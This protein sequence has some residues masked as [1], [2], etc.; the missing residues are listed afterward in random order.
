MTGALTRY[1]A[2]RAALAEVKNVDEVLEVRDEAERMRLYARQAKDRDLMANAM[3]IQLRAERRLGQMLKSAKDAGQIDRGGR[4]PEKT[5]TSAEPVSTFRLS[6]VGVD[7]KLSAK[8]QHIAQLDAA[9]F[10]LLVERSRAKIL[11]G[12]AV[13]VNPMRDLTQEEKKAKRETRERELG[14]RQQGLPDKKYGVIYADPEWRFEVWSRETGMDRAADN[15]Y[16]TSILDEIKARPVKEIAAA[17]CVLF[18]W[19]TR[20]MLR[21]A[22]DLLE[23]WGFDYKTDF[24]WAKDKIGTGY[25]GRDK[26]E[27]LLVG[28]IGS[29]PAPAMGTQWDSLLEAPREGHSAKPEIFAEMIETYFPTM[30]KIE[31][32]RRGPPRPGWDAWGNEAEETIEPDAQR[33]MTV[34]TTSPAPEASSSPASSQEPCTHGSGEVQDRCESTSPPDIADDGVDLPEWLDRSKWVDGRPPARAE[35]AI[36]TVEEGI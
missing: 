4:P 34:D 1:D 12:T 23:H 25:W 28:T 33:E 9:I 5:G 10:D 19:A 15:Q 26:H 27:H 11:A 18:L 24:C 6:E 35:T 31:L 30:P 7:K 20:P 2:A 36:M 3:E 16:P 17:D 22:I 8:A 29:P 13:V 32:N 14:L 21:A